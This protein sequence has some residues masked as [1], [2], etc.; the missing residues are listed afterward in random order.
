MTWSIIRITFIIWNIITSKL[1]IPLKLLL[2]KL[3]EIL[4]L[5]GLIL[6]DEISFA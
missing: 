5:N 1:I 6:E 2:P 3:L 4:I